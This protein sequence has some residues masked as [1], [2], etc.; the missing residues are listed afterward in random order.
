MFV[1]LCLGI[2]SQDVA[3]AVR[4]GASTS[5]QV[6]KICGA[7]SECGRCRRTVRAIIASLDRATAIEHTTTDE[8]T[9]AIEDTAA[10]ESTTVQTESWA[11]K[12]E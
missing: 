6:A 3:N 1:C 9:A 2:T 7:G 4:S 11:T 12:F 8:P 10:V 5:K